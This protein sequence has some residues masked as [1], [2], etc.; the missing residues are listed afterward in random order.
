MLVAN[1]RRQ[2]ET[3][4]EARRASFNAMSLARPNTIVEDATVPR[5]RLLEMIKAVRRLAEQHNVQV[6]I[7]AHAGDGNLHPRILCDITQEDEMRRVEAFIKDLFRETL[8]LGGTLTG[9]HGIGTL[10]APFLSWQFGEAGVAAMRS[11]K[12]A[13]DPKNILN[14]GKMFLSN[15]HEKFTII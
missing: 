13:L 7:A 11:I 9:E 1:T 10:K 15:P 3:L 2:R 6:A 12:Q 4:W 5:P 14:P 8:A